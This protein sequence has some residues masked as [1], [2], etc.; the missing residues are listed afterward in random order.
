MGR[1]AHEWR[2][3]ARRQLA[4]RGVRSQQDRCRGELPEDPH[5]AGPDSAQKEYEGDQNAGHLL[6]AGRAS[7]Q[8][9][10]AR[11]LR[12]SKHG[13]GVLHQ[14]RTIRLCHRSALN[15]SGRMRLAKST[16]E[17]STHVPPSSRAG[18]ATW[19]PRTLFEVN[20]GMRAGDLGF[21]PVPRAAL[22]PD[23]NCAIT[24]RDRQLQFGTA[25]ARSNPNADLS[26]LWTGAQ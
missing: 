20:A 13:H 5:C 7:R 3:D 18:P 14:C 12:R 22:G 16:A 9:N 2:P 26:E 15:I 25:L 1:V 6:I 4:D 11:Q 19:I 10:S 23:P 24:A 21:R 8:S 17:M